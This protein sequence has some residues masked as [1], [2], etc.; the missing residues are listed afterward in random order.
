MVT[1]NKGTGD[2]LENKFGHLCISYHGLVT[3]KLD[4]L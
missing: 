3:T 1:L 4:R 2:F